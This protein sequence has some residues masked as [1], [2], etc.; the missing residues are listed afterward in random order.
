[1][2]LPEILSKQKN[3]S[4]PYKKGVTSGVRNSCWVLDI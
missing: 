1:V 2:Y 4:L 3:I